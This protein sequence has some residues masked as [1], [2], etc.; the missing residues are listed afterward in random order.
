MKSSILIASDFDE[1]KE[2]LYAAH[3]PA[4]LVIFEDEELKVETAKEVIREAYIAREREGLIAIFAQRY[5]IHAQSALLKILE[6]PPKNVAF[7]LV[8]KAKS[9][10]LPTILSRLPVQ[11]RQKERSDAHRFERFDLATLYELQRGRYTKAQLRALLRG[12]VEYAVTND[13]LLSQ[14]ELD[15]FAKALEL[16]E[17]NS[18]PAS[19]L[20]TAGLILLRHQKKR[21][22]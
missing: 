1:V 15:Y 20:T 22:R 14:R 9:T 3:D 16:V 2:E 10:F 4:D 12:M 11:K 19:I 6:E 7:L 5:N 21:R 18:P 8:A 13:L 17:L